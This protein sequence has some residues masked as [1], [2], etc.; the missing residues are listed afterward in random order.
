MPCLGRP[1]WPPCA[2]ALNQWL[3]RYSD[4]RMRRT[5]DRPLPA[6][7]L[8]PREVLDL[9]RLARRGRDGLLAPDAALALCGPGGVLTFVCY[10]GVYTPLKSRTT[11]NTLIGAVPGAMPPVIGWCAVTGEVDARG[12]DPVRHPVPLAGAALPRHR[13][14]LPGGICPGRPVHAAGCRSRRP[15]HRPAD[16]AVLP[17]ADPGQ[18]WSGAAGAAG[19][20]YT[21]GALVLGLDFLAD[22]LRFQAG[23]RSGRRAR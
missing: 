10:V 21:V 18:P 17:G 19:L 7:R 11:L 8:Q 3:E 22:A 13:L 6:G 9:R 4:A 2:S 14:D 5:Q 12:G 15:I 16:G 20:V 23:A 1:W